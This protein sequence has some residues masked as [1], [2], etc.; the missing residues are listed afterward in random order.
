MAG[1]A[2]KKLAAYLDKLS[3]VTKTYE[4]EAV[5]SVKESE[6]IK[7]AMP[8]AHTRNLFLKDKK[9][10]IFLVTLGAHAALDL[11]TLSA[12][13]GAS[14]RLS[15]AS[16]EK[17]DELLGLYPGAVSVFGLMNDTNQNVTLILDK[18]LMQN[19]LINAHPMTNEAT[20]SIKHD[21]LIRFIEATGH[22]PHIIEISE[23]DKNAEG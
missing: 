6:K 16:A 14:G 21:D 15:F 22:T 4:H 8:G 2:R 9:G 10:R 23:A 18:A 5:F 12:K 1:D 7:L 3:I 13:I 19:A 20:T 17:L 11:K